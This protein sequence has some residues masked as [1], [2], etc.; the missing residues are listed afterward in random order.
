MRK[1]LI[2]IATTLICSCDWYGSGITTISGSLSGVLQ[3]ANVKVGAFSDNLSFLYDQYT[4][5]D[6]DVIFTDQAGNEVGD[7]TAPVYTPIVIASPGLSGSYSL[8]LPDDPTT[9]KCVIAWID[10]GD[11]F[12]DFDTEK[13][14]LPVK[15]IDGSSYIIT[16][17]SY[18]EVVEQITYIANYSDQSYIT[19]YQDN[20]D[21]IGAD[22]F[23]FVFD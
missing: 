22:G 20:L 4:P 6:S 5:G 2:I 12:Y 8:S 16:S 19:T 21:A 15:T 10:D 9:I 23:N 11:N 3:T 13:A 7:L 17:F 18:I 14:Y 1:I